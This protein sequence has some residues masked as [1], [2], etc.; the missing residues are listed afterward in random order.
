MRTTLFLLC[1]FVLLNQTHGQT[2]PESGES[3]ESGCGVERWSVKDLNDSLASQINFTPVDLNVNDLISLP[4]VDPSSDAPRDTGEMH[5]YRV[6]CYLKKF[7]LESDGDVHLVIQDTGNASFTMIAEIPDSLCPDAIAGGHAEDFASA[8]LSLIAMTGDIPDSSS[9]IYLDPAPLVVLTGVGYYD[10][11]HGQTGKAPNNL[12]IHPVLSL[13]PYTPSAVAEQKGDVPTMAMLHTTPMP[14]SSQI[15]IAYAAPHSG[16][17]QLEIYNVFGEKVFERELPASHT[18][19]MLS[20]NAAS[21]QAGI[22]FV[23]L[24]GDGATAREK[25]MCVK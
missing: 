11:P 22:Y 13:Q 15:S 16:N 5:T 8:R 7:K 3:E 25:I 18:S 21:F 4:L 1:L 2:A 14:F 10:P 20:V 17:V 12:E 19:G 23:L 9:F 6:V 24:H